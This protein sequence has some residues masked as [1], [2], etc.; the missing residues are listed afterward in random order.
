[1]L[2]RRAVVLALVVEGFVHLGMGIVVA[3]VRAHKRVEQEH[4]VNARGFRGR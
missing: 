4:G 3:D 2:T 1:M